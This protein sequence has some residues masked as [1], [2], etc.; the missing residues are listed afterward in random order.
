MTSMGLADGVSSTCVACNKIATAVSSFRSTPRDELLA[1]SAPYSLPS[2]QQIT[3]QPR[4]GPR[5]LIRRDRA[6][7]VGAGVVVRSAADHLQR[8]AGGPGLLERPEEDLARLRARDAVLAIEHEE[9][10]AVD[11]QL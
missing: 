8:L 9:G 2:R 10:H 6:R 3:G 11:A 7:S 5:L 1:A 4:R